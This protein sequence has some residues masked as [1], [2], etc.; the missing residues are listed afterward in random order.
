[1]TINKRLFDIRYPQSSD[2]DTF[3]ITR[4]SL[5][6]VKPFRLNTE[7]KA[8]EFVEHATA[9]KHVLG[10]LRRG[11]I[12]AESSPHA[13]G[14]TGV[15]HPLLGAGRSINWSNSPKASTAMSSTSTC[16]AFTRRVLFFGE[17]LSGFA[18]VY[19]RGLGSS[20]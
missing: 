4:A 10:P 2:H 17:L 13:A 5:S 8:A 12:F 18:G 1:L 14:E 11:S 9:T 6:L 16:F 19:S 7:N 3:E 20:V 15:P